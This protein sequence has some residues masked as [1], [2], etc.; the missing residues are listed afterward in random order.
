MSTKNQIK[1]PSTNVGD[2]TGAKK[3]HF[4]ETIKQP[5]Q[6]PFTGLRASSQWKFSNYSK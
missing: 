4:D 1:K 3:V 6:T 5:P 2:G